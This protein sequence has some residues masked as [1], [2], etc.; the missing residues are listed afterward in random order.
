MDRHPRSPHGV[1]RCAWGRSPRKRRRR[2]CTCAP[3]SLRGKGFA[4][5]LEGYTSLPPCGSRRAA[6]LQIIRLS[7]G[8]LSK[9]VAVLRAVGS[10]KEWGVIGGAKD[11]SAARAAR[12]CALAWRGKSVRHFNHEGM[13]PHWKIS[14]TR[15]NIIQR[16]AGGQPRK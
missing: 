9:R 8:H 12:R 4:L 16:R 13:Y 11:S 6:A 5:V 7:H 10:G 2:L 14:P 3:S 15:K 1:R